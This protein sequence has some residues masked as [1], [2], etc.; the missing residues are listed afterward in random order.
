MLNVLKHFF[1]LVLLIL[2]FTQENLKAVVFSPLE[3][4][5]KFLNAFQ[6]QFK[7]P[8]ARASRSCPATIKAVEGKVIHST[9]LNIIVDNELSKK[10][11]FIKLFNEGNTLKT[12][13][14]TN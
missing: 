12:A 8:I 3:P 14:K 4:S 2:G 9:D 6:V 11:S 13:L 10:G 1:S 7:S 5:A